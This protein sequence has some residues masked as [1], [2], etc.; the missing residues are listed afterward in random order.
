MKAESFFFSY[1][2]SAL[3]N[4]L[5]FNSAESTIRLMYSFTLVKTSFFV[6]FRKKNIQIFPSRL[7]EIG[8]SWV[9]NLCYGLFIPGLVFLF[10]GFR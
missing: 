8:R 9:T 7:A 6:T 1:H 2:S 4:V 3:R 10:N 5:K